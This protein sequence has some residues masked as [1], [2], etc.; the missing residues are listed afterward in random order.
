[1]KSILMALGMGAL[2]FGMVGC[3]VGEVPRGMSEDQ[4]RDAIA[5]M[6]P[7]DRIR[8]INSS[9]MPQAEKEAQFRQIEEET[10]V[11]AAEVLAGDGGFNR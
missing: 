9:P 7:E 6:S 5:R 11:R 1:M 3:G 4:A 8:A 10:G 2:L